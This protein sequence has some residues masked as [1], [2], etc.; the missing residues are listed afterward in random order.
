MEELRVEGIAGK[1]AIVTGGASGLGAG[2]VRAF[3]RAG[4]NVAVADILEPQGEQLAAELG[5]G[6]LF[7]RTDLRSDADID[8]LLAATQARFGRIDFLI[9]LACSYAEQG[10]NSSRADWQAVF[11]I[12][13]F[14]H[15]MLIQKAVPFLEKSAGASVV[16]FSSASGH[17]AQM[18]RWVY[19][20]TKAAIEQMTRSAALELSAR[21]IRVNALLPGMVGK[22]PEDYPSEEAATKSAAMA[23]RSSM[24]A[25]L[26]QPDE[27]AEAAL[28]LCSS[29]A[30]FVT[31][32]C[33]KVDGG[34]TALGPMARELHV[35][36]RPAS[37]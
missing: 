30:R 1:T 32:S 18:G 12:N 36:S 34:Y 27:V 21:G 9:N 17:I 4:V 25:R 20:A 14:G 35:P 7:R 6:C 2:L 24:L 22:R 19:P 31:G 11:D 8:Q 23:A 33:L 37:S 5:A 29:H 28:F 16:N 13:L 26:Q 3:V 10:L 15:A